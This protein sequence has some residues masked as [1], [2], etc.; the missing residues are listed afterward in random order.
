MNILDQALEQLREKGWQQGCYGQPEG[1]YCIAGA[2]IAA[3]AQERGI[4]WDDARTGWA[5]E[6]W[7]FAVEDVIMEQ[8]PNRY[9]CFVDFND[10]PAVTFEQVEVVLEKA[11]LK[12]DEGDY[13]YS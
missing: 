1:P 13:G 4:S 10:D 7:T 5:T 3:R 11:S 2:A 6:D 12:L 9:Q 8:Y